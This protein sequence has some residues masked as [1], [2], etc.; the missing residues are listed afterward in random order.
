[1]LSPVF[2]GGELGSG[3]S[4]SYDRWYSNDFGASPGQDSMQIYISNDAGGS[5]LLVE[6]VNENPNV[7]VT[8]EFVIEDLIAPTELGA[9]A[10]E[11]GV[12]PRPKSWRVGPQG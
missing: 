4:L 5:W 9:K 7:W 1:M 2:S 12:G 6:D 11:V 3:L 10:I 8:V